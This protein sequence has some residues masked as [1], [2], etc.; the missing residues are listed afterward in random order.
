MTAR[1]QL[2]D[3]ARAGPDAAIAMIEQ[4]IRQNWQGLFPV[5]ADEAAGNTTPDFQ[6]KR[7]EHIDRMLAEIFPA[8]NTESQP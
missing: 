7:R 3:L 1:R 4:T 8:D 5:K 2:D 6:R